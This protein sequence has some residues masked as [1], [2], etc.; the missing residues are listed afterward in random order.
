MF[1]FSLY[2]LSCCSLLFSS[3]TD[4]FLISVAKVLLLWLLH[5]LFCL[6]NILVKF[7]FC[8]QHRTPSFLFLVYD[9]KLLYFVGILNSRSDW[10]K[11]FLLFMLLRWTLLFMDRLFE[12]AD[13]FF[14]VKLMLFFRGLFLGEI[15]LISGT[16][17]VSKVERGSLDGRRLIKI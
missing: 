12:L 5:I 4:G 15:S 3:M 6:Q 14:M 16:L 9:V 7:Y 8:F 1:D 17:G 11:K 10:R 13:L 2:L